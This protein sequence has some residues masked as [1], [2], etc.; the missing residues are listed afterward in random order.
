MELN[1]NYSFIPRPFSLAIDHKAD[2]ANKSLS[3]LQNIM[4]GANEGLEDAI[5]YQTK[6]IMFEVDKAQ[7]EMRQWLKKTNAPKC[8]WAE[9]IEK[10]KKSVGEKR[11]KYL[12]NLASL[13]N[14]RFGNSQKDAILDLGKDV[15]IIE[16][17]WRVKAEYIIDRKESTRRYYTNEEMEDLRLFG[18]MCKAI[19]A[20]NARGYNGPICYKALHDCDKNTPEFLGDF[21]LSKLNEDGV[22]YSSKFAIYYNEIA[23]KGK[24]EMQNT[25]IK[26]ESTKTYMD[27]LRAA[28]RVAASAENQ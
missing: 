2:M 15:E 21:L 27:F 14:V 25:S 11:L 20:F 13:I 6:G 22:P 9:Y 8:V 23:E 10:A 18:E 24:R 19:D 3:S 5:R 26:E 28:E 16:G 7:N 17:K 4:E 12:D 1:N